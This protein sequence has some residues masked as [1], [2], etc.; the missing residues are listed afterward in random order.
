MD[1][2]FLRIAEFLQHTDLERRGLV[3]HDGIT[4]CL[5][6]I[7]SLVH[8]N[9]KPNFVP[10]EPTLSLIPVGV[11]SIR[12]LEADIVA[13]LFSLK[14]NL[15]QIRAMCERLI[16]DPFLKKIPRSVSSFVRF[17]VF[18]ACLFAIE[19]LLQSLH[20]LNSGSL[21]GKIFFSLFQVYDTF[22]LKDALMVWILTRQ[23]EIYYLI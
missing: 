12:E 20:Q 21:A 9:E 3:E 23:N 8:G 22:F 5:Q 15:N 7:W 13:K 18:V 17:E 11:P 2:P 14:Q 6:L 16:K 10:V 19:N 1:A 4:S